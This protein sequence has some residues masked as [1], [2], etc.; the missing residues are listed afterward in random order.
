MKSLPYFFYDY[1]TVNKFYNYTANILAI[2]C[3]AFG[4]LFA[5]ELLLFETDSDY[6]IQKKAVFIIII[7]DCLSYVSYVQQLHVIITF[8]R[9]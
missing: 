2:L 9:Q 3:A 4:M 8:N 7:I 6:Q 5:T 1:K